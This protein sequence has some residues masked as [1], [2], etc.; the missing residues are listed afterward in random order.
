[1]RIIWYLDW[2]WRVKETVTERQLFKQKVRERKTN[3]IYYRKNTIKINLR[4]RTK[5]KITII[6]WM[7]IDK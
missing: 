5:R 1:M 3:L 4:R 2:K 7:N 6:L